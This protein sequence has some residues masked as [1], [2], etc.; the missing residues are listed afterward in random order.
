MKQKV[1]RQYSENILESLFSR[2]KIPLLTAG[3]IFLI[4]IIYDLVM[5]YG[6][7]IQTNTGWARSVHF[8]AITCRLILILFF[9]FVLFIHMFGSQLQSIVIRLLKNKLAVAGFFIL[10]ALML[11]AVYADYIADYNTVVIKQDLSNTFASPS[12]QALLGTDEFG[13]DIFA[14]IVHGTRISLVIGFISVSLS[15]VVGGFLGALAGYFGG[16]IDNIIMRIMDIFLAIPSILLAIAIVSALGSNLVNL[17]IA[18]S[19]SSIPVYARIVRASVLS[20]RGQE[21]IEAAHTIGASNLYIIL[22]HIIPNVLSP[23]I[24]QAT[25]GIAAAI[26]SIAG[27]SFIGL[28]VQPPTP[29]WG[30]MLAG[31]RNFIRKAPWV[32]TYPGIAIMLSIL[33]LNLLGDGLR[34]ALDPRLK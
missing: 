4:V 12:P 5:G 13:R 6:P 29:E 31:G 8:A 28:G 20:V 10:T 34:D 15:I 9:M 19:I 24:V 21:F 25:L 22:K 26:L 3:F 32:T 18:L 14:R 7:S 16:W 30:S 1:I 17:V 11:L 2:Y 27:L 33:S 23:I